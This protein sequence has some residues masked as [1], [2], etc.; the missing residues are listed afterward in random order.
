MVT[1]FSKRA[2]LDIWQG[3]EYAPV[4][5]CQSKIFLIFILLKQ[6]K[7]VTFE[8]ILK[9]TIKSFMTEVPIMQK[10]VHSFALQTDGLT[11]IWYGPSS[12]MS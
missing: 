9:K 8:F 7:K 10:P 11:S 4:V 2:I 3:F 12:W 1:V 6:K 5:S